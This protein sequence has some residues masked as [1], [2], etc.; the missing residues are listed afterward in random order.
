MKKTDVPLISISSTGNISVLGGLIGGAMSSLQTSGLLTTAISSDICIIRQYLIKDTLPPVKIIAQGRG[1]IIESFE[2][3]SANLSKY[4]A[5]SLY[6]YFREIVNNFKIEEENVYAR[7]RAVNDSHI[8][9]IGV[10]GNNTFYVKITRSKKFDGFDDRVQTPYDKK[11]FDLVD[12]ALVLGLILATMYFV[13]SEDWLVAVIIVLSFYSIVRYAYIKSKKLHS[14][15]QQLLDERRVSLKQQVMIEKEWTEKYVAIENLNKEIS[16]KNTILWD[17]IR[18]KTPFSDVSRM[19]TA[20]SDVFYRDTEEYLRNKRPRPAARA[21]DDVKRIKEDYK[22]AFSEYLQML[23]KYEFLLSIFPEL[24][25]YVEDEESLLDASNFLNINNLRDEYDKTRD[26]LSKEEYCKLGE[27]ERNQLA[28]DRYIV[29]RRRSNWVA[30][31]EYEMYCCHKLR[32]K[33]FSVIDFGVQEGL[34]DLGRD[35][36][37]SYG[38]CTYIIQC[39]RYSKDKQIHE[40]IICQLFGTTL[41]YRRTHNKKE[42]LVVPM[43]ITTGVLSD[44][45]KEFAEVLN[46]KVVYWDMGEYPMI[47]C[48]INNGEKIYH[49]PFD[50]Q[51][52]TTKIDEK[53]GEMYAFTVKEAMSANF[54]RA[55]RWRGN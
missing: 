11:H 13:R 24:Q 15:S 44:R 49:L 42:D 48:N 25:N 18:S 54:R 10:T 27:C 23:Y 41:H 14:V 55:Y 43:L 38:N 29:G 5:R 50:Q 39:K 35:I 12:F 28:L 37:A 36:I 34:N 17:L 8:V 46:I 19:L 31:V 40:N 6:I 1:S 51:Y 22:Q 3:S 52:W 33:G 4:D 30:G 45:A 32:T 7:C 47:K 26:Y 21:A 16:N 9:H 53:K 2:I 20:V